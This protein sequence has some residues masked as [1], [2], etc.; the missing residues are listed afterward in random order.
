MN[1][2]RGV[3]DINTHGSLSRAGRLPSVARDLHKRQQENALETSEWNVEHHLFQKD[4]P[5]RSKPALSPSRAT[6]GDPNLGAKVRMSKIEMVRDLM[7][8]MRQAL[9]EGLEGAAH[10]LEQLKA[11]LAQLEAG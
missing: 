6:A 1:R 9:A 8:E 2:I 7:A 3:R 11:R 10:E 4:A 5:I